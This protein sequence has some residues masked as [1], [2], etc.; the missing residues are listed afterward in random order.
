[1]LAEK[2]ASLKRV[3]C[4]NAAKICAKHDPTA[5]FFQ[6]PESGKKI[7]PAQS[8]AQMTLKIL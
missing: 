1:M 5:L 3:N 7:S 6:P 2:R 8:V 4:C